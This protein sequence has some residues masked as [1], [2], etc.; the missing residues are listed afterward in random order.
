[1]GDGTPAEG[2]IDNVTVTSDVPNTAATVTAHYKTTDYV[3]A[4]QT[5]AAGGAVLRFSIGRPTPLF[6][7]DVSVVVGGAM[8]WTSFE[9]R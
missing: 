2:G 1:M 5:N 8:C 4:I 7:V 9:P 6:T 3:F